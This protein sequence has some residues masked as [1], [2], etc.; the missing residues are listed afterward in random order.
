MRVERQHSLGRDNAM[1]RVERLV[2]ELLRRK[3][4][5][6]VTISQAE[7]LW[8]ENRMS[9]AFRASRGFI[10]LRIAGTMVVTDEHV[11]LE[12]E[13]PAV[14]RALIGEERIRKDIERE[15]DFALSE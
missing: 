12:S 9:F 4:P 7:R 13:L 1:R 2:D 3:P 10:G 8:S 14:A 15:L 5:G 6:G 11:V